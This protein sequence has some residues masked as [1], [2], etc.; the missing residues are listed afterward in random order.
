MDCVDGA[1]LDL[2]LVRVWFATRVLTPPGCMYSPV[3][4]FFPMGFLR[5]SAWQILE[6]PEF[7]GGRGRAAAPHPKFCKE[8]TC[9][10]AFC[11][12]FCHALS[13]DTRRRLL[14]AFQVP[15]L[16]CGLPDLRAGRTS[17]SYEEIVPPP[18][19]SWEACRKLLKPLWEILLRTPPIINLEAPEVLLFFNVSAHMIMIVLVFVLAF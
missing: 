15:Q 7:S 3:F 13:H 2:V 12:T 6:S 1:V 16:P 17:N 4:V 11:R 14:L 10:S 5:N 19:I 8:D 18:D 9:F